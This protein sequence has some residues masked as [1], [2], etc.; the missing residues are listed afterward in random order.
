MASTANSGPHAATPTGARLSA[1][2]I[3]SGLE[4][5]N[6]ITVASGYAGASAGAVSL[7]K[8]APVFAVQ[9]QTANVLTLTT[10]LNSQTAIS[11][12]ITYATV[13]HCHTLDDGSAVTEDYTLE[14]DLEDASKQ[15]FCKW[16]I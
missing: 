1:T 2:T 13:S 5:V 15:N 3:R 8:K 7:Y 9:D 14:A 12:K 10:N 6:Q 16:L 11:V 4:D